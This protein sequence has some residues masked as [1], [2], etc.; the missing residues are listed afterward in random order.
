MILSVH[1]M[2]TLVFTTQAWNQEG[3]GFAISRNEQIS[4]NKW[5]VEV[6]SAR[7]SNDQ[8]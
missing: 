8:E 3:T 5:F 1:L 6:V 2:C 4:Y 7:F